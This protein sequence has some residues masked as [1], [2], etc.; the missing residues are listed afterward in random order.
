MSSQVS[1]AER[2][3]RVA[4]VW[5]GTILAEELYSTPTVV[6][7]GEEGV[8]TFPIPDGVVQGDRLVVLEPARVGGFQLCLAPELGGSVWIDG[9]RRSVRELGDSGGLPLGPDDYGVVT[10]GTLAV[11]FQHVRGTKKMP[12]YFDLPVAFFACVLLAALLLGGVLGVSYL[13]FLAHPPEEDPLQLRTELITRFMIVP[14]PEDLLEELRRRSGDEMDDPGLRAREEEAGGTAHEGERGRVG[15]EDAQRE[16]TQVEGDPA[17]EIAASVRDLGLLGALNSPEGNPIAQALDVPDISDLLAGGTGAT[18]TDVG[19]GS[20]G[21]GL[22]GTGRGGG[23]TGP[24]Q[25]FAG[26]NLSTGAGSGRGQGAGRGTDGPGTPGRGEREVQ[27]SVRPGAPRTNGYLSAEQINR[28]VRAHQSAIRYC[29]EVEVQRQPNL[30]G[31][32]TISWRIALSGG[33]SSARVSE[34]SLGNSRVEGCIVRQVR[35]W[36]FP[37][38]DGGE[39]QVSYP[40]IFGVQGG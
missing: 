36:R 29:Y 2:N 28:V 7:L 19:R 8:D 14:P 30:R 12:V 39:C 27:V 11:F 15:R 6:S 4:L 5:N 25:L 37:Q 33:V 21:A 10:V 24:G 20:R 26:G 18:R 35:R 38:P 1:T 9:E 23:G 17:D 16:D 32:I 31:R 13:D 40:F 22:R 34:S 3:L